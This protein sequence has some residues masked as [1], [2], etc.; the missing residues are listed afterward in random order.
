MRS[1][2]AHRPH[3]TPVGLIKERTEHIVHQTLGANGQKRTRVGRVGSETGQKH[4]DTETEKHTESNSLRA[5][6]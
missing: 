2:I 3:G 5:H 4:G 1:G 6:V